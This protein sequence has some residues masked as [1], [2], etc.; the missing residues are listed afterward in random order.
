MRTRVIS[1]VKDCPSK[2]EAVTEIG[3]VR[4]ERPV[5][6]D[7][8]GVLFFL[9][10]GPLICARVRQLENKESVMPKASRVGLEAIDI[11]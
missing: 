1:S 10:F 9:D 2:D 6:K 4:Q 5:E 3:V 11:I 7:R 8:T